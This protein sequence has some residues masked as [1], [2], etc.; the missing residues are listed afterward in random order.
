MSSR[1]KEVVENN[2]ESGSDAEEQEEEYS[3]EKILDKRTRNNKVEYFLKWNGYDDVDNT[4]EPE[5]NLDC[6]ELIRDFEEKLKQKE[7]KEKEKKKKD[8]PERGRKRTLSSSTVTSCAS[9]EAGPSG[10]PSGS[11]K[12]LRKTSSPQPKKRAE[13]I[14]KS[15]KS[16]LTEN[17]DDD[18]DDEDDDDDDD[19]DDDCVSVSEEKENNDVSGASSAEKVAEKIIGA[20]DSSGSLMFLLKWKG[21]EE[22][23]L[24]SAQEANLMCPQVV[25]KFYEERLT[26]HAPENKNGV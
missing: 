20:T 10:G 21:I 18:E 5:E 3:V 25:I 2:I 15:D 6:E 23:D 17:D 12:E 9:S 26:W 14:D 13:K 19:D 1:G 8:Q 24:I 4:W 16:D 7:L 11:S 22:A